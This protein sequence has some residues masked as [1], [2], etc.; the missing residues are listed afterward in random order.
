M[1]S[2][3]R[4]TVATLLLLSVTSCVYVPLR[5]RQQYRREQY[6]ASQ[7]ELSPTIASA[8][9]TGHVV[10]GM[11]R[12]QVWVV[13]GDPLRKSLFPAHNVEVWLYPSVRF[14]QD[15]A[16]SH[17]ASSFRLVFIDGILRLIE[18]I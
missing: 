3:F 7:R 5:G 17:G 10:P 1:L 18:P 13:V 2:S 9:Q 12:D 16:H 4:F 11:D 15:P 8:I 6:L 14:H